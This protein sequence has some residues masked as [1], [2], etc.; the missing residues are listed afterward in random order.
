M[1]ITSITNEHE[2]WEKT[3][4]YAEQCT[5]RAGK[6]L[7]REMRENRFTGWERVFVALE[8]DCIA[9]YCTFRKSDC[10]PDVPYTPYIGYLFVSEAFRGNRLSQKLINFVLEYA[11]KLEM[12]RMSVTISI[13]MKNTG[14]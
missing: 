10:I 11:R 12:D 13:C 3:A 7:A 4:G 5:W 9:G 1:I 6:D 8:G 14:L 2:I